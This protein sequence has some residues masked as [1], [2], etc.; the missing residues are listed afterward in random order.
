ML[1]CAGDAVVPKKGKGHGLKIYQ[2]FHFAS[3]LKRM[4]VIA[5]HTALGSVETE[6]LATVK[7]APETLRSMVRLLWYLYRGTADRSCRLDILKYF[8]QV[9]GVLVVCQ[10]CKRKLNMC[11]LL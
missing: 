10:K 4:S 11:Y 5:G 1:C 3:A 6:Y 2:R 8:A 7:G 9:M